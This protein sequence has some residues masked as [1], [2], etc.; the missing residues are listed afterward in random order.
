MPVSLCL[1]GTFRTD[2]A[3]MFWCQLQDVSSNSEWNNI[4]QL[5]PIETDLWKL[6]YDTED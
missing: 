6:A 4:E 1:G 3:G 5:D 2:S